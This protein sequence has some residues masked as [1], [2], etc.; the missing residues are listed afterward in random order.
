MVEGRPYA[1]SHCS[2]AKSAEQTT[3]VRLFANFTVFSVAFI[4]SWVRPLNDNSVE[5]I[6]FLCF[7]SKAPV[8][9]G[10]NYFLWHNFSL[11]SHEKGDN[12]PG[13]RVGPG[14]HKQPLTVKKIISSSI[15]VLGDH[16]FY[17]L[18]S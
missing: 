14:G 2:D 10:T 1:H 7:H 18:S 6:Q 9:G 13:T 8:T 5:I 11:S 4:H 17:I 12:T 15:F 3:F 16:F